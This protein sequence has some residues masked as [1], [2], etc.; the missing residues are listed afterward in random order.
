MRWLS[1]LSL[2]SWIEGRES[3]I[4]PEDLLVPHRD[5]LFPYFTAAHGGL[6]WM[7]IEVITIFPE[8]FASPFEVG[9]VKIAR[10]RGLVD[11]RLV[12]LRDFAGDEKGKVD[13]YPYGG[14]PGMVMQVGPVYSAVQKVMQPGS[15]LI[16]LSAQGRRYDQ[17]LARALSSQDHLILVCGRYKGIDER[18]RELLKPEEISIGDYVLAGGELA[19]LVI[20]ESVV[21]LIPGVLGDMKSAEGDSFHHVLLEGPS[22]TRPEVFEGLRVPEVL[23]SG[24]HERV[25]LWRRRESLKRTLMRRPDLLEEYELSREDHSM[26]KD[27]RTEDSHGT[28]RNREEE[29]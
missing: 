27:I 12:D 5:G 9:V 16:L 13:D 20:V 25:R 28:G 7:V 6:T 22:Y 18:V 11:L 29:P 26:L 21:R 19:A 8:M 23:L 17:A 1:A 15:H 4:T 24:D 10:E 3:H 14:G 2:G